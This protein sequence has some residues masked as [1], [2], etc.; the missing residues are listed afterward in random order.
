MAHEWRRGEFTISTDRS[1]LDVETIHRYLSTESY[2]ALG[3]PLEVVRRSIEH[4]LPFGV[5]KSDRLA[6]FARVITDYATFAWLADVFV[7]EEFRG[8]GL[9]KWLVE[10]ILAHPELQGFRRWVLATKD[11]HELYRRHGFRE[12]KE[13]ARWMERFDPKMRER[14]DYWAAEAVAAG[15]VSTKK[16]DDAN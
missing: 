6:G 1:R 9:G 10:V 2:W 15:A 5:Y 3:R 13:P 12:L 8:L 14:P 4:S 16:D 7:L 11:A